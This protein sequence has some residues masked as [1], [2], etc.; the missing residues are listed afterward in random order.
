[1]WRSSLGNQWKLRGWH[2]QFWLA[3]TCELD[4]KG[5]GICEIGNVSSILTWTSDYPLYSLEI[6][7]TVQKRGV[8]I[9]FFTFQKLI[10]LVDQFIALLLNES[11]HLYL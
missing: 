7:Y 3:A 2:I 8:S 11:I 1:M 10:K 5:G 9:F 6:T 4:D